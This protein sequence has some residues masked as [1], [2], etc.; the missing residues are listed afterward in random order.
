MSSFVATGDGGSLF[1]KGANN[2]IPFRRHKCRAGADSGSSLLRNIQ[3]S[4]GAGALARPDGV[5]DV[6]SSADAIRPPQR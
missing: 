6:V 3:A 5:D 1:C 2:G 4:R